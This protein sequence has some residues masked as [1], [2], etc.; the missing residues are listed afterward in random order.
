MELDETEDFDLYEGLENFEDS[1]NSG[2]DYTAP[3]DELYEKEDLSAEDDDLQLVVNDDDLVSKGAPIQAQ[4]APKKT[5]KHPLLNRK[6]RNFYVGAPTS[7]E[8]STLPMGNIEF[9]VLVKNLPVWIDNSGLRT[10][11]E[12]ITGDVV[13]CKVLYNFYNGSPLGVGFVE[14]SQISS[15]TAFLKHKSQIGSEP[16]TVDVFSQLKS[17][18]KY[19]DG[20]VSEPFTKSVCR[21]FSQPYSST[22]FNAVSQQDLVEIEFERQQE[23]LAKSGEYELV[24]KTFPWFNFDLVSMMGNSRRLS[25]K[26]S[27]PEPSNHLKAFSKN[28]KLD[29]FSNKLTLLNL[30]PIVL[31]SIPPPTLSHTKPLSQSVIPIPKN[32]DKRS[33]SQKTTKTPTNSSTSS[34]IPKDKKRDRSKYEK[35]D[36]RSKKRKTKD[37]GEL[38]EKSRNRSRSRE[39]SKQSKRKSPERVSGR[40]S[41]P[42][43][44]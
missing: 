25:G 28:S 13:Y 43:R 27:Q 21:H 42:K 19:R 22:N 20:I 39:R 1:S 35:T 44:R 3:K 32:V 5:T 26:D 12:G 17:C 9:F 15:C 16:M 40:K 6:H 33:P 11:V 41:T 2:V 7:G 24:S 37:R 29:P 34:E 30:N 23:E 10:Y 4:T 8:V 14:F 18:E 38:R 31:P 36:E